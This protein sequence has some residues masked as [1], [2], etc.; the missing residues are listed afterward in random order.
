MVRNNIKAITLYK[1]K[2]NPKIGSMGCNLN[3]FDL[4]DYIKI[5]IHLW[6]I[7]KGNILNEYTNLTE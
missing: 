3:M 2:M 6:S 5:L 4:L 7:K 1:N